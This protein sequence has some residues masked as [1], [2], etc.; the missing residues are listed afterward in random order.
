MHPSQD[1]FYYLPTVPRAKKKTILN[2]SVYPSVK[3]S[4]SRLRKKWVNSPMGLCSHSAK[5]F[6]L[7]TPN[8][9]ATQD[10]PVGMGWDVFHA[11]RREKSSC[12]GGE[13]SSL[14][15]KAWGAPPLHSSFYAQHQKET[16]NL[17][18]LG[19]IKGCVCVCVRFVQCRGWGTQVEPQRHLA[20]VFESVASAISC[21]YS[22]DQI[23]SPAPG[24][25]PL[26]PVV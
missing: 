12:A 6:S 26:S 1:V 21:D 5:F 8:Q 7:F 16:H 20:N 22:K 17:C 11:P 14:L 18:P 15:G 2:P 10:R 3:W 9:G 4:L 24:S 25:W 23:P 19:E 13:P